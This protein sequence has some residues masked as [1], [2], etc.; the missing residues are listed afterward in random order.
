MPPVV[1]PTRFAHAEGHTDVCYDPTGRYLVTCGSDGEVRTWEGFQDDEPK[2][3]SVGE[4]AL[5]VAC[6]GGTFF[7]ATD[8][9][10]VK[11]FEASTGQ[12]TSV[13]AHFPSDVYAVACS[14]DG[15][16]LV[17]GSG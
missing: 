3:Y 4:S 1:K 2:S 10:C 9:Y 13:P 15:K 5:A 17:A 14:S 16:T 7:V 8:S 12:E 6:G 11:A